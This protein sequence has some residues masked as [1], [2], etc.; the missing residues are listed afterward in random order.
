MSQ[1]QNVLRRLCDFT[2]KNN[3]LYLQVVWVQLDLWQY[4][5][6]PANTLGANEKA[7]VT[8]CV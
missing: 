4:Q 5:A 2:K 8:K 7:R 1:W 3:V 6:G